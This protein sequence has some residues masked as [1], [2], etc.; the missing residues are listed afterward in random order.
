MYKSIKTIKLLTYFFEYLD[1]NEIRNFISFVFGKEK[2]FLE[3]FDTYKEFFMYLLNN[4]DFDVKYENKISYSMLATYKNEILELQNENLLEEEKDLCLENLY[5]I[6]KCQYEGTNNINDL[7]LGYDDIEE[8]LE[9]YNNFYIS[10]DN[11]REAIINCIYT[12]A[13]SIGYYINTEC[14]QQKVK[15]FKNALNKIIKEKFCYVIYEHK[16][17]IEFEVIKKIFKHTRNGKLDI[18]SEHYKVEKQE[19]TFTMTESASDKKESIK[20]FAE[21]YKN[22]DTSFR[23]YKKFNTAINKAIEDINKQ[24]RH[25]NYCHICFSPIPNNKKQKCK[26]C[27][28][29]YKLIHDID[30]SKTTNDIGGGI[31]RKDYDK[32]NIN[33]EAKKEK[34]YKNLI[35]FVKKIEKKKK[36]T[37]VNTEIFV[38]LYRLINKA[39]GKKFQK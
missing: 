28:Q 17:N 16:K 9:F 4:N 15:F 20:N 34:H 32:N 5:F 30:P 13:E 11:A 21:L 7:Y 6:I 14:S 29:I 37:D 24:T 26:N 1:D 23:N 39:F 19:N 8:L 38:M 35:E 22:S 25:K 31:K 36:L 33:I 10:T 3:P 27:E 12:I 18:I 2:F